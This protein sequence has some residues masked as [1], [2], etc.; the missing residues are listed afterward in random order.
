MCWQDDDELSERGVNHLFT[1]SSL[2]AQFNW[3]LSS[4]L[5]APSWSHFCYL[6]R[7][8]FLILHGQRSEGMLLLVL[9]CLQFGIK[10]ALEVRSMV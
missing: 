6:N 7:A 8:P 2:Q 9:Y 3:T 10:K 1:S 4:V 5:V